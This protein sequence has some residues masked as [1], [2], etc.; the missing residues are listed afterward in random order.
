M[1]QTLKSRQTG[2]DFRTGYG[3]AKT[4]LKFRDSAKLKVVGSLIN[5]KK[6]KS[7]VRIDSSA[8]SKK[9]SSIRK[10]SDDSSVN[11]VTAD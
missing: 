1:A 8:I 5:I 7:V 9:M 6:V 10:S 2:F 11:F 4:S 3:T